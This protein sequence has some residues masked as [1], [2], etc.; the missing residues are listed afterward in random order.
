MPLFAAIA[1]RPVSPWVGCVYTKKMENSLD[2]CV[3]KAGRRVSCLV[4]RPNTYIKETH[5]E[6][7]IILG[8]KTAHSIPHHRCSSHSILLDPLKHIAAYN[9]GAPC[10]YLQEL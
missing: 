1:D 5:T 8:E 6:Q 4:I 9:S 2:P 7:T 10:H 3:Y